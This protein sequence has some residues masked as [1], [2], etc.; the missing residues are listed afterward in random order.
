M[1]IRMYTHLLTCVSL[2]FPAPATPRTA[3]VRSPHA[4]LGRPAITLPQ[5]QWMLRPRAISAMTA[6]T[7]CRFRS[8]GNK[9]LPQKQGI[10]HP[11][12]VSAPATTDQQQCITRER[13]RARAVIQEG[14]R[15]PM[16]KATHSRYDT[17]TLLALLHSPKEGTRGP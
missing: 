2:Q 7:A 3:P 13:A 14:N 1:Y 8:N 17:G 5:K 6:C 11:R 16:S 12:A 9:I 15:A 10:L 4:L